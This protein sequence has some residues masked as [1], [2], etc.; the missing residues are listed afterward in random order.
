M[1]I[2]AG[3]HPHFKAQSELVKLKTN[4]T[5]LYDYNDHFVKDFAGEIDMESLKEAVVLLDVSYP[6]LFMQLDQTR[7]IVMNTDSSFSYTMLWTESGKDF[8]CLEP[9]M[10]K[11][12][13]MDRKE[14]LKMIGPRDV[15]EARV[16]FGVIV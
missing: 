8:V 11:T 4:A 7:K 14:E 6:S 5:E 10:A 12:G 3:F 2:Y 9:W 13:E 1:P 15:L 16:E